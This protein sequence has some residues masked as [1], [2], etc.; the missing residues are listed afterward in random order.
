MTN[1]DF[2]LWLINN[3]YT[4][5]TLAEKLH[6]NAQTISGYNRNGRYPVLFQYALKGLEQAK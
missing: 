1:K 3:N 6:I 4:Q 2:K 5:K